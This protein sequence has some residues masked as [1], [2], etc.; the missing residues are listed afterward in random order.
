[1][2]HQRTD[3]SGMLRYSLQREAGTRILKAFPMKASSTSDE[4]TSRG[5]CC[6][7]GEDGSQHC[8]HP[9]QPHRTPESP[10]QQPHRSMAGLSGGLSRSSS[11][12]YSL[13][14]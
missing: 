3:Q 10:A 12:A 6:G 11:S 9:G 5:G 14:T 1:M 8:K 7:K 4:L 2:P 13:F